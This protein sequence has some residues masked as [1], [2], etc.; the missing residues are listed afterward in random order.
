MDY[1]FVNGLFYQTI[2][3]VLTIVSTI[4]GLLIYKYCPQAMPFIK[5]STSTFLKNNRNSPV[6]TPASPSIQEA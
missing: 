4:I 5:R 2:P 3:L 1:N 6:I